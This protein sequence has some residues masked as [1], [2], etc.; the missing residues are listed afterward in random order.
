MFGF[1]SEAV[2]AVPV[3]GDG[4]M[5]PAALEAAV[6][7]AKAAGET[8]FYVNAT[9]GTT[10]LGSFDPLD[11]L[12]DVC[13]AHGLW[14]H[15]DGSWGGPVVFSAALGAARL[16]GVHRADSV[17]VTPHKM[18]GVPLTCS[19]LL[20]R[21]LRRFHAANTLPAGYL[22]HGGAPGADVFDLA[23]LTP[24]CGRRGDGLKL[25]L[26]WTYYGRAGYAALVERA[27]ATAQRLFDLLAAH[28]HVVMVSRP[29]LP[30]LQVCFYWAPGR[31]LSADA[32][33]NGRVTE[34]IVGALVRRG[35]MVDFAP[36]ERGRFFR[37]VVGR[38][39]RVGSVEGLVRAIED[40]AGELERTDA[41]PKEGEAAR[42]GDDTYRS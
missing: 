26:G 19:F 7:R 39:T 40:V 25:F 18:L 36:G 13:A 23:D 9:A 10:V 38:D 35:W 28:P 1:G 34:R 20:G 14:L 37:V 12:A 22:F 4:R 33:E 30:C 24:Q 41:A 5:Q 8:P 29:P 21:D 16:A 17:A 31:R 32:E 3:D 11:A 2:R 6:A 42:E 15:V 27:F